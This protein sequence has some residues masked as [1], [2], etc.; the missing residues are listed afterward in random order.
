MDESSANG[1]PLDTSGPNG[2]RIGLL[3]SA[4][5]LA[6]AI[7]WWINRVW[8]LGREARVMARRHST[9]ESLRIFC[10]SMLAK[11]AT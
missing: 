3:L 7:T 1:K 10:A 9:P 2:R 5:L 11:N 8:T 4:I 6:A